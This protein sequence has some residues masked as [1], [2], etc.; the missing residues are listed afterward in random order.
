LRFGPK[1]V[2]A[3]SLGISS[4]LTAVL[5]FL[6]RAHY[7]FLLIDRFVIGAAHVSLISKIQFTLKGLELK[8][9]IQ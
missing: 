2:L 4:I 3:I 6:A 7:G 5:P 8:T 9:V 1:L